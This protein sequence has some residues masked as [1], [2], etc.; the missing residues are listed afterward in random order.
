MPSSPVSGQRRFNPCPCGFFGDPKRECRCSTVQVQ[1]YRNR[2]SGP[3]RDSIDIQLEVPAVEL[4]EVSSKQEA[5]NTC[6][7]R[8]GYF[9]LN[10][11]HVA[12]NSAVLNLILEFA[13]RT[14]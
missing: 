1:R 12:L 6:R 8:N 11:E 2:I 14:C 4:R 13:M 9:L 3:L 10:I 5:A 7:P